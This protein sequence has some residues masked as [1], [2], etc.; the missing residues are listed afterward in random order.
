MLTTKSR[1]EPG[2][3]LCGK[4]HV[5]EELRDRLADG[6]LLPVVDASANDEPNE[7]ASSRRRALARL[8]ASTRV[9][10]VVAYRD[11]G[12]L[13]SELVIAD[14][15]WRLA[16]GY[17]AR[18]PYGTRLVL[19]PGEVGA[20][21]SWEDAWLR[22][23][24]RQ[25][26]LWEL[27]SSYAARFPLLLMGAAP[28]S[29]AL[30][31]LVA[32]LRPHR[33]FTPSGWIVAESV[34]EDVARQWQELGLTVV[35]LTDEAFI[36]TYTKELNL[37]SY[38]VSG[39]MS[40]RTDQM[41]PSPF[42]LLD[43]Y[44]VQ[45]A[46]IFYARRDETDSLLKLVTSN[47]L[48]IVTGP[49][50]AGKTSLLKAGLIA[51]INHLHPY[52]GLYVRFMEDPVGELLAALE[53]ELSITVQRPTGRSALDWREMWQVIDR[54]NSLPVVI[55]DQGEELFT[56]FESTMRDEL[57]SLIIEAI[58]HPRSRSR[59][60]FGIR[61]DYLAHLA[62][63][64]GQL[65]GILQTSFY[66]GALTKEQAHEAIRRPFENFGI[67]LEAGLEI[68]IADEIGVDRVA[69]PQIQIV[70]D[71]LFSARKS[72][73]IGLEDYRRLGGTKGIL[74]DFLN[75]QLELLGENRAG[76]VEILKSLVTSEGTKDVLSL[77]E[78]SQRSA[79]QPA[80]SE[81]LVDHL[82]TK[83]RLL[84][85]V[86][87]RSGLRYELAHEYLTHEIWQWMSP[88]ELSRRE[89]QE[90]I[91]ADLRA[92]T[93]FDSLR[94]GVD[95]LEKYYE[96]ARDLRIDENVGTLLL[97]SSV[98]H[99]QPLGVWVEAIS[100]LNRSVQ[101]RVAWSL[102]RFIASR[103]DEQRFEAA[104]AMAELDSDV[105]V[106]A[107]SSAE[108]DIRH[109]ALYMA[110]G[111]GLS[112]AQP[113]LIAA[114]ENAEDDR[115]AE[116]ACL[117]LGEIGG[118]GVVEVLIRRASSASV[119]V[120]AAAVRGLGS[121]I[122]EAAFPYLTAALWGKQPE[123]VRAAQLGIAAAVSA[124]LSTYLA[125]T[126]GAST[127]VNGRPISLSSGS[128]LSR[129][130]EGFDRTR[131]GDERLLAPLADLIRANSIEVD[132]FSTPWLV[133]G[134]RRIQTGNSV[135]AERPWEDIQEELLSANDVVAA[136]DKYQPSS[137]AKVLADG[138]SRS[139][140]ILRALSSHDS[141]RV[142]LTILMALWY[143][144]DIQK[145][146]VWRTYIR[147]SLL[148]RGLQDDSPGIRYFACLVVE[149]LGFM[150]CVPFLRPLARDD[151]RGNW[152]ASV[153]KRV[154]DAANMAL[155]SLRPESSVWR[156]D[157]QLEPRP[158]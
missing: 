101:T 155:D 41:A 49:S 139:L 96:H 16:D 89:A 133:N 52:R 99:S 134:L 122:E 97:L 75:A 8:L 51:H 15:A 79:V 105:I 32:R 9:P 151:A 132:Q 130:L 24:H 119:Q 110:G 116:L 64:A 147:P 61:E 93:T 80:L 124:E 83:S 46:P 100:R 37:R 129:I 143:Y 11:P 74:G 45:D 88:A 72:D 34:T 91:A 118:Q 66:V 5:D 14:S 107:L 87:G 144:T 21:A 145:D 108:P 53:R 141:A 1:T 71:K 28:E 148:V 92:W 62:D 154:S 127:D 150:E 35:S 81:R 12:S 38:S 98:R 30:Q 65:P 68:Q 106:D 86:S 114:L 55:F 13:H 115:S 104:E 2:G 25:P 112:S 120:A 84:R 36:R 57:F 67:R 56:R 126:I 59:F 27:M 58:V 111:L 158:L 29:G 17:D 102:L 18:A 123:M 85:P 47:R 149:H 63:F 70:C 23:E 136:L 146:P 142:R 137:V 20:A 3:T 39:W 138:G 4:I 157:W 153:G 54:G 156:K 42:K 109:A 26:V 95:R 90:L 135:P 121:C 10:A 78:L 6:R 22:V 69:S 31:D 76:V 152:T 103:S 128:R 94:L 40:D 73:S 125:D 7:R 33:Y 43:Y 113:V 82:A 117:A 44:D 140:P 131:V 60:V 77:D 19:S 50:G 48:V